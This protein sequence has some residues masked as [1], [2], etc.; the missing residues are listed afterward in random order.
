VLFVYVSGA[1]PE[2]TAAL[3]AGKAGT[4]AVTPL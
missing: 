1:L 2:V 4:V 3:I